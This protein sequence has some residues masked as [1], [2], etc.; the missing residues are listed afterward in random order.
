MAKPKPESKVIEEPKKP[1]E[2]TPLEVEAAQRVNGRLK[3]RP[4]AP[5]QRS[6][7][8]PHVRQSSRGSERSSSTRR[9][10]YTSALARRRSPIA[11]RTRRQRWPRKWRTHHEHAED[12]RQRDVART[13]RVVRAR[14]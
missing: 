2:M 11:W 8:E 4:P 9:P 1:Y 5:S 10:G 12:P 3:S 7:G 14:A 13:Q 6:P